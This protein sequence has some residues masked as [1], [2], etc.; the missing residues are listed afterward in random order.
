MLISVELLN[1]LAQL[2]KLC[3][4]LKTFSNCIIKVSTFA[5]LKTFENICNFL[6]DINAVK[7]RKFFFLSKVFRGL[8]RKIIVR[9][10]EYRWFVSTRHRFCHCSECRWLALVIEKRLY[11]VLPRKGRKSHSADPSKRK[12]ICLSRARPPASISPLV[13]LD[14]SYRGPPAAS[15]FP[16]NRFASL[17]NHFLRYKEL[18]FDAILDAHT[19]FAV[20]NPHHREENG[21]NL[22]EVSRSMLFS[23]MF[24]VG[25][26]TGLIDLTQFKWDKKRRP[27]DRNLLGFL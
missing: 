20:L 3:K 4:H 7:S 15:P 27:N 21:T 23:S 2:L 11:S 6:R 17:S 25:R 22:V 16:I 5:N 19:T 13:P 18:S 24:P 1:Y 10:Q 12:S 8:R 26:T 14:R 9:G